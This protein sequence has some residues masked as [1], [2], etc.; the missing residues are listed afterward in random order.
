MARVANFGSTGTPT[1]P[2]STLAELMA[3]KKILAEQQG[4]ILAPRSIESWTQGA[5]QLGQTLVNA[6]QQRRAASEEAA[7]REQFAQAM[8]GIDWTKGASP[9]QLATIAALDPE[10]GQRLMEQAGNR[11]LEELKYKRETERS[12]LEWNRTQADQI[13]DEQRAAAARAAETKET[14]AYETGREAAKTAAGAQR[15]VTGD[16][17]AKLG[18]DPNRQ[19]RVS[20]DQT[21]LEDVTPAAP[22]SYRPMTQEEFTKWG[23][24]INPDTG[25]PD[26]PYRFNVKEG[27]PEAI[28]GGPSVQLVPP[29]TGAKIGLIDDFLGNF[30]TI[31]TAAEAGELTGPIDYARSVL[32]GR[33]PGGQAYRELRTGTEGIV[34]ILTGAGMPESEA[35]DRARQYEPTPTDDAA[36]LT[37]KLDGLRAAVLEARSGATAGRK[38]PPPPV[39]GG[40]ERPTLN[41]VGSGVPKGVDPALWA[42]MT[43][44]EKAK[45]GR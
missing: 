21:T 35:R 2:R 12:D 3:R 41:T 18:G 1:G 39:S 25:Q 28:G 17:A 34:R 40:G 23:I 36:T 10:A 6:L 19:Y 14:R 27:K 8:S 11:A 33:G 20:V 7:G 42:E 45:F 32:L 30:D 13:A 26:Q 31:R 43:P 37:A 29:E 15:I 5:A 44:E 24:P 22:T 16:E 9:E 4:D 38:Y